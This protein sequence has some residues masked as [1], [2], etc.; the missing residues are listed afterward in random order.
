[1]AVVARERAAL[2]L[3]R[4]RTEEATHHALAALTAVR[5]IHDPHTMCRIMLVL[6]RVLASRGVYEDAARLAGTA[7][8]LREGGMLVSRDEAA[9]LERLTHL[10]RT[11]LGNERFETLHDEG[12]AITLAETLVRGHKT[13]S[14]ATVVA[15]D[16]AVAV[17]AAAAALRVCALGKTEISVDGQPRIATARQ[18]KAVELLLY[19]LFHPEGRTREQIGLALWPEA[20]SAQTKNNFHVLLHKLRKSLG[21]DLDLVVN[22]ADRYRIDARIPV[23]FDATEFERRL[24]AALRLGSKAGSSEIEAT[25]G[26]YRGEFADGEK[27][28]EWALEVRERLRALCHEGLATLADAQIQS[29]EHASAVATLSRL[30]SADDLREDACRQLISC[31]DAIGRRDEAVRQYRRLVVR[32]RQ[33]L[34][35]EPQPATLA[36]AKRLKLGGR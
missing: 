32:L 26:L 14:A 3:T 5:T 33:E 7:S 35:V 4:N 16:P 22:Q 8:A 18:S 15:D 29:G 27:V 1:M 6:G 25:L 21:T 36:L 13:L 23:W 20:S 19:L 34:C 12:R 2:A 9:D 10:V 17:A 24:S 28:G 31:L 11:S 30:V